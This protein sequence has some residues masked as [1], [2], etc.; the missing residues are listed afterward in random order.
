M[1]T[2]TKWGYYNYPN[3]LP[4]LRAG[5]DKQA[6]IAMTKEEED[7][8]SSETEDGV[9]EDGVIIAPRSNTVSSDIAVALPVTE[10]PYNRPLTQDE[11]DQIMAL[12][13]GTTQVMRNDTKLNSIITEEAAAYFEGQKTLEQTVDI[14]QNRASIYINESR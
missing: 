12:I 13:E 9:I 4:I 1:P 3:G 6:E 14:I 10:D 8:V 7:S 11:V 5:L 2:M